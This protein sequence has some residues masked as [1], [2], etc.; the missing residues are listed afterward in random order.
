M[1]RKIETIEPSRRRFL[2]QA[3]ATSLALTTGVAGILTAQRAPAQITSDSTRPLQSWGL[4]IGDVV[5][6]RAIV[7]GRADRA[8]RLIVEW[9]REESFNRSVTLRGPHALELSDYTA[10]V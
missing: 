2:K 1:S 4:Q 5:D 10:R 7:W 8:S 3:S 9:S 6:D